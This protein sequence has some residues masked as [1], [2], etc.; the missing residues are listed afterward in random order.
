MWKRTHP[1]DT[2][3]S[4]YAVQQEPVN[5]WLRLTSSGWNRPQRSVEAREKTRRSR[6]IA[7]LILGLLVGVAIL[8]P[9][10]LQDARARWILAA[11]AL[12]LVLVA[13]LNRSGYVAAA[14]VTLVALV[15]GGILAA[16]LASPIGLTM[17]ELPNFDAYVV[18]VVI[19]TSVLPRASGFV[20]AGLNSLLI[21]G[22][23]AWQ[24]HNANI[25]QDVHLYSSA[26][27]Q[28]VSLLVRPI[29]LQFVLAVVAYLWVRGT[30]RAIRRADRAEEI[31]ELEQREVERTRE[32]EE[33]VHQLLA[34]H[35]RLANGDFD[36]R[37]APLRSA[38][39]WQIGNS[40]NHLI[41]RL[42]AFAQADAVLGR[43]QQTVGALVDVIQRWQQGLPAT[44]P[45]PSGT[46]L[47]PLI[48][49]LQRTAGGQRGAQSSPTGSSGASGARGVSGAPPPA[50][51]SFGSSGLTSSFGSGSGQYPAPRFGSGPDGG[52]AE[53]PTSGAPMPMPRPAPFPAPTPVPVPAPR[54]N[55]W[56]TAQPPATGE[57]QEQE[58]EQGEW[59]DP[60][61]SEPWPPEEP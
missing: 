19:A 6:L 8:S 25:A 2:F 50:A 55:P 52:D 54:D 13:V 7:W 27:V 17:G 37:V 45:A 22:N 14:G 48:T 53:R 60:W 47:D 24:P 46:P 34:V 59:F 31:A 20:V 56:R 33:G 44:L 21:V 9:L 61:G 29:A 5:G 36:A 12:G 10:A 28:T 1:E 42:T 43:T 4:L 26:T 15:S 40:L 16:N 57:G 32:I 49:L 23:Y 35:V 18:P 38:P 11:W 58:Q 51:P 39:L 3:A 30:D 41:A